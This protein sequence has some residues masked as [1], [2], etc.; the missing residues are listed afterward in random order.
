EA[1]VGAQGVGLE[2]V[3]A[4]K[5]EVELGDHQSATSGRGEAGGRRDERGPLSRDQGEH[6]LS[7]WE[8]DETE[9]R[10]AKG[11]H[12]G[13]GIDVSCHTVACEMSQVVRRAVAEMASQALQAVAAD[14]GETTY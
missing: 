11:E 3:R 14:T 13:W 10:V 8:G 5:L 4:A 7:V 1:C 6:L 9:K 2:V 12:L